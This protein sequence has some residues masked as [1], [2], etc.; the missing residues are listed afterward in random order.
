MHFPYEPT[1]GQAVTDE[2]YIMPHLK[3][4]ANAH[5]LF[6][7]FCC[8]VCTTTSFRHFLEFIWTEMRIGKADWIQ[9]GYCRH[10]ITYSNLQFGLL[11]T[12]LFRH[13]WGP[14]VWWRRGIRS[15]LAHR[16]RY[17]ADGRWRPTRRPLRDGRFFPQRL[18]R[19]PWTVL[20][21][22]WWFRLK[23][24]ARKSSIC[25]LEQ[26]R[27]SSALPQVSLWVSVSCAKCRWATWFALHRLHDE[28]RQIN[29]SP[30]FVTKLLV[31]T[32]R[33]PRRTNIRA[34][35]LVW[36]YIFILVVLLHDLLINCLCF[37]V[38]LYLVTNKVN[39]GEI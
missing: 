26:L 8:P 29:A 6:L 12:G 22:H 14:L 5:S 39:L 17:I 33:H 13:G 18:C 16:W 20:D 15:G 19:C 27:W 35:D 31:Q 28:W 7:I 23:R 3:K 34:S 38:Y 32:T 9:F 21:Q 24:A 25:Q 2:L 30:G 10:R 11:F 37:F 4:R 1:K 36:I